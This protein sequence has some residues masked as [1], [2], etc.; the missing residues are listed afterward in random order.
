[1]APIRYTVHR[2]HINLVGVRVLNGVID[3]G[4]QLYIRHT[5]YIRHTIYIGILKVKICTIVLN[6]FGVIFK[7]YLGRVRNAKLLYVELSFTMV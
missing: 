7:V 3:S 2:C 1:M 5:V 4:V 6:T